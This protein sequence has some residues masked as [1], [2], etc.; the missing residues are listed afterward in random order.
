MVDMKKKKEPYPTFFQRTDKLP[1]KAQL[2]EM[3]EKVK[4]LSRKNKSKNQSPDEDKPMTKKKEQTSEKKA[5]ATKKSLTPEDIARM[6]AEW[7]DKTTA[8]WADEFGVSYQTVLKMAEV[9][10][11][12]DKTLCPKKTKAKNK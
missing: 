12:E 7:N 3:R 6:I 5:R 11:K 2:K 8:E 4:A 9:I 10:R 1:T